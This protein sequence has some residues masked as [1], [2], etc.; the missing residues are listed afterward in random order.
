MIGGL[1]FAFILTFLLS[2]FFQPE[3][4]WRIVFAFPSVF[5]IIQLYNLKFNFPYETPKFL[6]LQNDT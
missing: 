2:L 6:L 3:I 4:Y 1:T 5:A